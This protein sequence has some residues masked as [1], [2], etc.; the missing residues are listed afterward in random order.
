MRG[1]AAGAAGTTFLSLTTYVDIAVR[2][3][4]TSS[5]PEQSVDRLAQRAGIDLG[6]GEAADARRTALGSCSG[7]APR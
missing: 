6:E 7:T 1:L 4:P 3:R 5:V 2:G